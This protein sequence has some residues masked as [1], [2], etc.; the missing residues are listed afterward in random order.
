[1]LDL[2]QDVR[3]LTAAVV[4]IESVSGAEEHLAGLVERALTGLPHLK[5][6]R[7]GNTV[8]ARTT[9][10]RAERVVIAGHLDTVPVA[11]NL[12][13]R[14]EDGLLYG[15]GTSDMKAGVAV[16]LKLAATVPDPVRDVTYVFYDCEEIEAARNGLTRV[17]REHPGWLA[18]DFAVLMEPTDGVIEGGCQGTLRAEIRVTGKRAHSAR[19]WFGVNAVHGIEP[20]LARLNAYEARRPVVDGLEYHEGLNAV[21]VRGGVAGNVI[22]D[23]CVVTVNYRFAPDL[24]V[25]RARAH[26]REVFDGYEVA[27]VDAAPGARPGLTHPVA[28]A[29]TAAVGGTP[30]AKLGWT[31]VARFSD[32]GVPAVNYGPGDPNLAHQQGEYVTL[33]K[34][35]E[36]ERAMRAWLTGGR[37]Q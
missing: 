30:R 34:I 7:S 31:D 2:T 37:K 6:D 13:S 23:E 21:G 11:G 15:C 8:V 26:V 33:E 22:P 35:V 19:S 28:A 25:E 18:A 17:A 3:T 4:D 36:G 20:V 14:V 5:V 32:L 10:G 9:L 27:F 1:M 29:F 12:P 24:T 16:A